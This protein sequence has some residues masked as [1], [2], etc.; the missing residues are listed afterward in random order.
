MSRV[1][2]EGLQ[3]IC[4]NVKLASRLLRRKNY[5]VTRVYFVKMYCK[6]DLKTSVYV[7]GSKTFRPDI[8][9]PSKMENAVRDI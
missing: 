8:K 3:F 7:V 1:D 5:D 6:R 9:K 4:S 2:A